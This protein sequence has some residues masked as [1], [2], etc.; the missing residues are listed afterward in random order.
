MLINLWAA[1]CC[2]Q[3]EETLL[4]NRIYLIYFSCNVE[5]Y[6]YIERERDRETERERESFWLD[7]ILHHNIF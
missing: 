2:P 4:T 7:A 3:M 1:T 6:I 5:I